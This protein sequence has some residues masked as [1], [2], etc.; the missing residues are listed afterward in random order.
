MADALVFI[1]VVQATT[2]L[3]EQA[4]R[5]FARLRK[6]HNR[7][8]ALVDVLNRHKNEI[9][10]VKLII[11]ILDDEEELQQLA[12]VLAELVR[13]QAVQNKLADLLGTLDPKMRSPVNQFTR[14]LV[15][16]SA[17][18]KKLGSIMDEMSHIK[19]SLLLCIQV[20]NVGVTRSIEK[21]IVA[22]AEVIQ[23][24]DQ[25]LREHI[26]NCE[27]LRIA[28]LLKGRRPSN[29]GTVPLTLADLA[30]LNDDENSENS[31]DETLIGDSD[32]CSQEIP[33][34]TE[35]IVRRNEVHNKALQV[36]AA[37]GEDLWKDVNRLVIEDNKAD[38][39]GIQINYAMPRDMM[40]MM[41]DQQSKAI[42]V[43]SSISGA[44]RHDRIMVQV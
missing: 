34:K 32:T 2:Q 41:L 30:S 43:S 7:Q 6:A 37:L 19:S 35:R 9:E 10:S 8:K 1:S 31:G 15:H 22:N 12:T 40:M 44:P 27:G 36:N 23:R 26:Q 18:E 24:I 3:I 16:G 25:N 5:I 28:R 39:Q 38:S 4:F 42:A 13:M 11:G 21:E 29:D 14:Q 33:L 20:S 17:D